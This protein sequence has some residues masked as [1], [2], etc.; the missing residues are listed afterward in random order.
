MNSGMFRGLISLEKGERGLEYKFNWTA[1]SHET[2]GSLFVLLSSYVDH[3]SRED[4]RLFCCAVAIKAQQDDPSPI[5]DLFQSADLESFTLLKAL[6][7][8]RVLE[9]A[10]TLNAIPIPLRPKSGDFD[11]AVD[12]SLLITREVKSP[13]PAHDTL[14]DVVPPVMG[15]A[16]MVIPTP[17]M[18]I[19]PT[20]EG[21]ETFHLEDLPE[22]GSQEESDLE[23]ETRLL[24][25]YLNGL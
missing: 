24:N 3:M 12:E 7:P 15:K 18:A 25:E 1:I 21:I 8:E 2:M 17:R 16:S 14:R 20:Q 4:K 23:E 22:E 19:N 5:L 13:Y 11:M 10:G 9:S 6:L